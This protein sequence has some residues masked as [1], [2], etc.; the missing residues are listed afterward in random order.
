MFDVIGYDLHKTVLHIQNMYQAAFAMLHYT[1]SN[2]LQISQVINIPQTGLVQFWVQNSRL[3]HE[4]HL[5]IQ[6]NII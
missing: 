2:Y 3:T 6:Y 5:S 4:H 1:N